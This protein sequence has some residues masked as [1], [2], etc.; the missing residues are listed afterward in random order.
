M[1]KRKNP[2]VLYENV[3]FV[4]KGKNIILCDVCFVSVL[5]YPPSK[6]VLFEMKDEC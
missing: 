6:T 5:Q 1:S 4:I 2:A 3:L